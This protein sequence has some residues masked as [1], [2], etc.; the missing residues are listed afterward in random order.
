MEINQ[1]LVE[2][3][4]RIQCVYKIFYKN[5]AKIYEYWMYEYAMKC[6]KIWIIVY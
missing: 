4:I 1:S 3:G 5:I 6:L 2:F